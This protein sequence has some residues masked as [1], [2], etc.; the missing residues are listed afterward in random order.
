MLKDFKAFITRG[1]LVE[2]AVAFVLGLAFAAVVDS[3]VSDII[4]PLIAA[5]FH[6]PDFSG[7]HIDIGT[8]TIAYGRFL[9]ALLT[10]VT[11]AFAMF[12]IVR[13]YNRALEPKASNTKACP[14]CL[15]NVPVGASR[16]SACTSALH[17][18][19]QA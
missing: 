5:V 17:D 3:L 14:F 7:L 13:L 18:A 16:C 8:T 11:V 6:Q 4:T 9:N 12:L 19:G 2:L 15:T 1:N 10:F